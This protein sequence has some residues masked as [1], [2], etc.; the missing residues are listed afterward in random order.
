MNPITN[1]KPVYSHSITWQYSDRIYQHDMILYTEEKYVHD[2]KYLTLTDWLNCVRFFL[3][4]WQQLSSSINSTFLWNLNVHHH[5]HESL[6]LDPEPTEFSSQN[7]IWRYIY[8]N[9]SSKWS[10][11]LNLNDQTI[12]SFLHDT[13]RFA[14]PFWFNLLDIITEGQQ[15]TILLL[16]SNTSYFHQILVIKVLS[17]VVGKR[18]KR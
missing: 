4:N 17:K 5:I 2:I 12:V 8:A 11:L 18:Q 13:A 15:I 14:Y 1:P 16:K 9:S 10:L 6:P 3:R 7:I